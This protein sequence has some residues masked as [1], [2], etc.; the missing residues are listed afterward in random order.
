MMDNRYP[1]DTL[2]ELEQDWI[3]WKSSV[4]VIKLKL[5]FGDIRNQKVMQHI[6]SSIQKELRNSKKRLSSFNDLAD[7]EKE[8]EKTEVLESFKRIKDAIDKS[9]QYY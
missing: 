9:Q 7:N 1:T 4:D 6:I 5:Q 8:R 2:Q 3:K